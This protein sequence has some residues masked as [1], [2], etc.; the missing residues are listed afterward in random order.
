MSGIVRRVTFEFETE[1]SPAS[2][3]YQTRHLVLELMGHGQ[4]RWRVEDRGIPGWGAP[5]EGPPAGPPRSQSRCVHEAWMQFPAMGDPSQV[6]SGVP[7][8]VDMA[9]LAPLLHILEE[10]PA[11][12]F[13]DVAHL[14][15]YRLVA[16]PAAD[17]PHHWFHIHLPKMA[18]TWTR[19]IHQDR[20][21]A[22]QDVLDA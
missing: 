7:R 5:S 11:R 17:D 16:V 9:W 12:S 21:L 15:F 8:R 19:Q 13:T 3:G 10:C 6:V 20:A 14:L 2:F 4:L 1:A 22:V 18:G